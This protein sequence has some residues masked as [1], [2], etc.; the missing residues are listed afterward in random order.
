MFLMYLLVGAV[1][2]LFL[3]GFLELIGTTF[4]KIGLILISL[5]LW[6]VGLLLQLDEF[7]SVW[8]S[9]FPLVWCFFLGQLLGPCGCGNF[10]VGLDPGHDP[11]PYGFPAGCPAQSGEIEH[12]ACGPRRV[13]CCHRCRT[14][15]VIAAHR[16]NRSRAHGRALRRAWSV[17]P[18]RIRFRRLGN[19]RLGYRGTPCRRASFLSHRFPGTPSPMTR[20]SRRP[21]PVGTVSPAVKSP[22]RSLRGRPAEASRPCSQG[23]NWERPH[24]ISALRACGRSCGERSARRRGVP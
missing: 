22:K 6:E 23:S 7:L 18:A 16:I 9:V 20:M 12:A 4:Q 24:G 10:V 13:R 21:P 17:R 1:L 15:Q 14:D 11:P 8:S 2:V 5:A 19:D 3:L